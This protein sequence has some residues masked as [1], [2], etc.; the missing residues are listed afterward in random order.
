MSYADKS[1]TLAFNLTLIPLLFPPFLSICGAAA[2]SSAALSAIYGFPDTRDEES[3]GWVSNCAS[4]RGA[5]ESLCRQL[6]AGN[7]VDLELISAAVH[8]GWGSAVLQQWDE[9]AY[10]PRAPATGF[11]RAEVV[12][13]PAAFAAVAAVAAVAASDPAGMEAG[14]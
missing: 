1:R 12:D 4:I 3:F 13:R 9:A 2:K 11:A 5:W 8:D 14:L 7:T 6:A 10:G